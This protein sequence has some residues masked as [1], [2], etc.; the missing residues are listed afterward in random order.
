MCV[1][2]CKCCVRNYRFYHR[3]YEI[4]CEI[5]SALCTNLNLF[6]YIIYKFILAA[7]VLM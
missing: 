6:S 7:K 3:L 2:M 1:P 5:T 4:E